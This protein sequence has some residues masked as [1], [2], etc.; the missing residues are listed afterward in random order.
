MRSVI[1]ENDDLRVV[2]LTDYG[3]KILEFKLKCKAHDLLY[4]N[5]RVEIRMPVYGV[6]VDNWWHGGI[7]ECIPTCHP[8]TYRGEE[9]PNLGEVWSL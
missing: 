5:P 2:V 6:N 3:A 9:Y 8:T 4:H 1:L 7:D